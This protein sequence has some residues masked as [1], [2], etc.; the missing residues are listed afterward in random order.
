MGF[1]QGAVRIFQDDLPTVS[2]PRLRAAGVI[3][4]DMTSATIALAGGTVEVGLALVRF[5]N[6]GSWS[7]FVAPCCGRKAKSLR[8]HDDQLMCRLCLR[9]HGV[10]WRCEPAG[11]RQRAA[12][13]IPK[14]KAKLESPIPLRLKPHLRYSKL[15]RRKR[16]EAALARW[17][18]SSDG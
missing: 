11:P 18:N 7:F 9:A 10:L 4:A 14:L 3:T 16:L 2:T 15:E 12:L 17:R 5:P 13:R 8:L 1:I 6:G